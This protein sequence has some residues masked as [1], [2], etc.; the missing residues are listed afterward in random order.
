MLVAA[1]IKRINYLTNAGGTMPAL[2]TGVL[3]H[4]SNKRWRMVRG[5]VGSGKSLMMCQEIFRRAS[6]QVPNSSGV[7][8]SRWAVIR[9]S[10][11]MLRDT[12]MK[13]WLDW[14]PEVKFGQAK[15]AP[16]PEH[17]LTWDVESDG[18]L[19]KVECEILFR[20]MDRTDQVKNLLSLE[21]TGAW[22]NEVRELPKAILDALDA[23]IGRFPS[24]QDGGASWEGVFCDTNPYD[25][26]HY[27]YDLFDSHK[28]PGYEMWSQSGEE[29]IANLPTNYYQ[30]I[31]IGKDPEW[32][33]IYVHGQLGFICDGKPVYPEFRHSIHVAQEPLQPN[34]HLPIICGVDF[35]LTPAMVWTQ[36]DAKG[37]WLILHEE[38]SESMGIDRFGEHCLRVQNQFFPQGMEF[39]YFADPAGTQRAQTDEKTCYEILS[40]KG[41][42]C[43][44]GAVDFTSRRE[45]VAGRL[46]TLMDGEPGMLINPSC[47]SL[48]KGFMGGY[49]YPEVAGTGRYHER[50][51]KNNYSHPHDAL[52]Y[53]ATMLFTASGMKK[54]GRSRRKSVNWR[55]V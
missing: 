35:G 47:K 29:N 50:P 22:V 26:D 1:P 45:A 34:P 41:M 11:P 31:S 30:N 39:R 4:S 55:T 14:F 32:V 42:Q 7:R 36:V 18:V 6:R 38:T 24:K 5:P 53:P 40:L 8:R 54:K 15:H 21:L 23:R 46:N 43:E 9:N 19:T 51:E 44:P 48:I 12:T 28:Y 52:Q 27:L 2:P 49:H 16:P 3:F 33:R 13:T 20:A 25:T 37:R 17:K 10:Y